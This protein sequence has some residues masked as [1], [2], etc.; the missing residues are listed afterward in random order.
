MIHSLAEHVSSILEIKAEKSETAV[1]SL[2]QLI[3]NQHWLL[4]DICWLKGNPSEQWL[5]L[6]YLC[7]ER[8]LAQITKLVN[9][10]EKCCGKI[11]LFRV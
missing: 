9:T 11:D 2:M 6:L 10:C 5:E 1:K 4:I 3:I 7:I 8:I